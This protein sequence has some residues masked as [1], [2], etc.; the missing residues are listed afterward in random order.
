MS[1]VFTDICEGVDA[2]TCGPNTECQAGAC[3]CA[4]GYEDVGDIAVDG[5]TG[6]NTILIQLFILF[7][8]IMIPLF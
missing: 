6:A 8:S 5:C 2:P 4:T 7:P 3:I 1:I